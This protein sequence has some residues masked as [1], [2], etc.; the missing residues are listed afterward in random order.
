MIPA[1]DQVIGGIRDRLPKMAE[2][3]MDAIIKAMDNASMIPIEVMIP[4]STAQEVLDYIIS[5]CKEAGWTVTVKTDPGYP[6]GD[7]RDSMFVKI[8]LS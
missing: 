5:R 8:V 3:I 2:K 4:T 7:Q 6:G 1:R